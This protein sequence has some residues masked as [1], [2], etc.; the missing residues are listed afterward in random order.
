MLGAGKVSGSFMSLGIEVDDV[1]AVLLA[2]GWH[3]VEGDS[4]DL[5]AYEF[6]HNDRL[7]HGGGQSG[8][9]SIG[10]AF[11][12]ETGYIAGPLTAILAVRYK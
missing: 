11:T 3:V 10:F 9:C 7:L 1:T 8:I 5:D 12:D 6:E 2:D 4:F